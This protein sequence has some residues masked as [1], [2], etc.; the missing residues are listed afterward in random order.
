MLGTGYFL[1]IAKINSQQEKPV[2]SKA[3]NKHQEQEPFGQFCFFFGCIVTK[4]H[5]N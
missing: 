1:K 2:C 3:L 5:P 4:E